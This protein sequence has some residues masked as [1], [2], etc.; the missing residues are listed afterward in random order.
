MIKPPYDLEKDMCALF[1]GEK[2]LSSNYYFLFISLYVSQP[3]LLK[4]GLDGDL[5]TTTV[6]VPIM[7]ES[8]KF[9]R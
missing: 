3:N 4:A 2:N 7:Y 6:G 8:T 5:N 1:I 9:I